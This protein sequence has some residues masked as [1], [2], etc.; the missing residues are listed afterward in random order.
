LY[1]KNF[2]LRSVLLGFSCLPFSISASAQIPPDNPKT[3]CLHQVQVA[4]IGEL[5]FK[6]YK[7]DKTG[8]A[9]LQVFRNG[10]VIFRR[11]LGNGGSYV[12]GQEKDEN[13]PYIPDGT[14]VTGSGHP[15]M[16]V[17]L[18]TGGAHCCLL[19]YVFELEPELKLIATLDARDGDGSRFQLI[20]GKYYFVA[21]DWTFAYW[22]SSFADSPAPEVIL[23]FNVEPTGGSYHLALEEMQRPEPNPDGW[24]K[25][26]LE[27]RQ[28]FGESNPFSGGIGSQ[29]WGNMLNF[30]YQGHSDLAWKL[31]DETWPPQKKGKDKFLSD[32]CSQL[33]TSPYWLDLKTIIP[34]P[35]PSCANARPA[36]T[37][38]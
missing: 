32:F 27:G 36:R 28:A 35:P 38:L 9:C 34:N 31:F 23:G 1:L 29:L 16:L 3:A 7:N 10:K 6:S 5:I 14:D 30:I 19:Y 13:G 2:A 18:Y 8:D 15:N 21:G 17:S 37:G 11:T 22:Q 4:S 12:L 20:G 26:L 33:K 25:A 24:K